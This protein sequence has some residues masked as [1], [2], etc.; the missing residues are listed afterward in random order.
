MK[1]LFLTVC[2]IFLSTLGF[3]K[4]PTEKTFLVIFDKNELKT[5]K[6]STAYI[7]LS[8]EQIFKTKSYSG[9]SDAAILVKVPFGNIDASQLGDMFVR[10]NANKIAP[11]GEVALKI[12]DLDES[13][14]AYQQLLTG[15]E[16]R[17][18]KNKKYAKAQKSSA[19]P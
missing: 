7:E 15:M 2:I 11:L 8:L 14:S 6:S 9:N 4:D 12:L 13:K 19:K 5:N 1:S 17:I 18:H 10:V 16:D 3:A